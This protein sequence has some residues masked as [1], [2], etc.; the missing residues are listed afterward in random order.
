MGRIGAM[1]Y[2]QGNLDKARTIFEGLVELD[3]FSGDA[4]SALG[5]VLT[6]Q[7]EDE[8]AE[9]HLTKAVE[10]DPEGIAPHVNLGE[11]FIR[12]QRI[13]DAMVHLR[14][15]IELDP[16]ETDPG[17]NRARAMVLG[18]YQLIQLE[19]GQSPEIHP[20]SDKIN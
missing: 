19:N 10:I 9:Q 8:L 18:I 6:L 1:H 5:A 4:R 15:A 11:V 2:Q 17:A 13:E 16:N 12:R 20:E 7:Q 3:P 14:K